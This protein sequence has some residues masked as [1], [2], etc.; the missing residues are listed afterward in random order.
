[1]PFGC[2]CCPQCPAVHTRDQLVAA[3]RRRIKA[4]ETSCLLAVSQGLPEARNRT[5]TNGRVRSMLHVACCMLHIACCRLVSLRSGAKPVAS[6]C[7]SRACTM[8]YSM[9]THHMGAEYRYTEWVDFNTKFPGAPD[10]DRV[11]GTELYDHAQD[12]L[13][14]VNI[15]GTADEHLLRNLSALL[16]KHPVAGVFF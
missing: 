14:N 10:W 15:A 8:G 5:P 16:R 9:L 3:H 2:S 12:P 11:V 1:M 7:L 6:A 13:E 4:C